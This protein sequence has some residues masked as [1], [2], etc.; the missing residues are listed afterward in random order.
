MSAS[1]K[2]GP[3]RRSG[4]LASLVARSDATPQ[5]TT[6]V[7]PGTPSPSKQQARRREGS[8]YDP[9]GSPQPSAH[10]IKYIYG[11]PPLNENEKKAVEQ[12]MEACGATNRC[13]ITNEEVHNFCHLV[14]R[15]TS[16]AQLEF[17]RRRWGCMKPFDI[18]GPE[19]IVQESPDKHYMLDNK[20][21][22][23]I[24]TG[25][26]VAKISEFYTVFYTDSES[27]EQ[28][29]PFE[30]LFPMPDGGWTYKVLP[31]DIDPHR[32]IFRQQ[33][34]ME[35]KNEISVYT[36]TGLYDDFAYPY[37]DLSFRTHANPLCALWHAGAE[38][39]GL[40]RARIDEISDQLDEEGAEELVTS[41]NT[42]Q[43]LY[44]LWVL[45]ESTKPAADGTKSLSNTTADDSPES[46]RDNSVAAA[47][48]DTTTEDPFLGVLAGLGGDPFKS[49]PATEKDA[50]PGTAIPSSGVE[51]P[52]EPVDVGTVTRNV[53]K[54]GNAHDVPNVL[55]GDAPQ[56]GS[57]AQDVAKVLQGDV[58]QS[59]LIPQDVVNARDDPHAVPDADSLARDFLLMSSSDD[60]TIHDTS[61][62]PARHFM[63]SGGTNDGGPVPQQ[64]VLN[65]NDTLHAVPNTDSLT[66]ASSVMMF[67]FG[68]LA[69]GD[70]LSAPA[71]DITKRKRLSTPPS[72]SNRPPIADDSP[73]TH[74]AQSRKLTVNGVTQSTASA[75]RPITLRLPSQSESGTSSTTQPTQ[76][77]DPPAQQASKVPGYPY[78]NPMFEASVAKKLEGKKGKSRSTQHDLPR[79]QQQPHIQG[80]AQ[81]V[82]FKISREQMEKGITGG[83]PR[84]PTSE[85]AHRASSSRGLPKRF[86]ASTDN[87]PRPSG[88]GNLAS[89][90][91]LAGGSGGGTNSVSSSKL[92]G[93][94][95]GAG[96]SK[97]EPAPKQQ[98]R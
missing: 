83:K 76:G 27:G 54:T 2:T 58:F 33:L 26:L 98:W 87:N 17:L 56:S 10:V 52:G 31:L 21:L 49:K 18:N 6:L 20:Q 51:L 53:G 68:D 64:D 93:K 69:I 84:I 57:A 28:P 22:V 94:E 77:V 66:Q 97:K 24:P 67:H 42:I 75:R 71:R 13:I 48:Q 40:P 32:H 39:K 23:I 70:T 46:P 4:R 59:G 9:D 86:V 16:E 61:S 34:Q 1:R 88:S 63:I 8:D 36:S 14:E 60:S 65:A 89:T 37:S 41:M 3:S 47:T 74:V 19:N 43:R 79:K 50:D 7:G 44:D 90:P 12:A 30:N 29:E 15:K 55:R 91:R 25:D 5:L 80:N 11:K 72:T 62:A 81:V 82:G 96:E 38:I 85:P 35:K 95:T 92:K 73:T 45:P 78:V